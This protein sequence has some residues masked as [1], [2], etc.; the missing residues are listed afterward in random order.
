MPILSIIQIIVAILLIVSI[1]LQQRG[2]ALGSAFGGGD[3]GG[4]YST[5][6]GL[7]KKLFWATIILGMVFVILAIASLII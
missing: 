7:Q 6:R 3:S 4:T 5:R 1:M 2:T